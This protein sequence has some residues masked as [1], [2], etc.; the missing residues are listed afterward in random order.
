MKSN[1]TS[2]TISSLFNVLKGY[3]IQNYERP[4]PEKIVECMLLPSFV[5][6]AYFNQK[7]FVQKSSVCPWGNDQG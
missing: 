4:F 3:S 2:S 5:M 6:S 7:F 1:Y